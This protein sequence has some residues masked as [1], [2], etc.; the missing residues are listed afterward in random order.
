MAETGN[1]LLN[2]FE[3]EKAEKAITD[4]IIQNYSHKLQERVDFEQLKL[5]LRKSPKGKAFLHEIDGELKTRRDRF[6]AK[7]SDYNLFAVLAE[8]LDKLMNEA[9]HKQR[10]SRQPRK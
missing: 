5:R 1:I 2:G 10:T 6:T 4:N 3:L 8:V 9:V 7:A